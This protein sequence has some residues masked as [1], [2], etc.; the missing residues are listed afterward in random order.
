MRRQSREIALQ[1]LFQTEFTAHISHHDFLSLLEESIDKAS[2]DY[3][4]LLINGVK[5][6][7]SE[8]DALIQKNSAHWSIARMGLVDKNILRIAIFEMIFA[9]EKI[10]PNIVINECIEIAK[11]YGTSDSGSFVNGILDSI[12]KGL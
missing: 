6:H 5:H 8:I 4:D 3:A 1:S 12:A 11:K 7:S 10:K 9:P 2:I